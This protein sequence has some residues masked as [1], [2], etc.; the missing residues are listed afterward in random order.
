M[1]LLSFSDHNPK[2]APSAAIRVV[3]KSLSFP[4]VGEQQYKVMASRDANTSGQWA[5]PFCSSEGGREG[6]AAVVLRSFLMTPT[7]R[8][9]YFRLNIQTYTS[10]Y[11]S[12]THTTRF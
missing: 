8:R 9:F 2:L 6:S 4:Y 10:I 3:V 11:I 7:T 1:L 12:L 5:V